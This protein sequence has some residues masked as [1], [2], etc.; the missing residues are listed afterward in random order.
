MIVDLIAAAIDVYE[1]CSN[2]DRL[3]WT[4]RMAS[5]EMS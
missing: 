1:R 2:V 3:S 4:L 5:N